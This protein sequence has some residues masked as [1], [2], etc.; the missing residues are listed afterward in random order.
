[1]WTSSSSLTIK[2]V[3]TKTSYDFLGPP[4]PAYL[5]HIR[6]ISIVSESCNFFYHAP[7]LLVEIPSNTFIPTSYNYWDPPN[8]LILSH[9]ILWLSQSSIVNRKWIVYFFLSRTLLLAC[10]DAIKHLLTWRSHTDDSWS[11]LLPRF[12]RISILT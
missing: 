1:M 9:N 12:F 2:H 8:Q 5:S 3:H 7:T 11:S 4:K 6:L 10:R